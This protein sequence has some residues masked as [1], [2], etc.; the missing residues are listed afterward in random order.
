[1]NQL[2]ELNQMRLPVHACPCRNWLRPR[3]AT[4][5]KSSLN[6]PG[7]QTIIPF[8][9]EQAVAWLE[10]IGKTAA[11]EKYFPDKIQDA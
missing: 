5:I 4:Q 6:H 10:K 11:L 2:H 7:G 9:K 1:M 8:S 3:K